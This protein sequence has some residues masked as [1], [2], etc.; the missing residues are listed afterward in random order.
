MTLINIHIK[1]IIIKIYI[2]SLQTAQLLI[3]YQKSYWRRCRPHP[4]EK[5]KQTHSHDKEV[6]ET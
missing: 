1:K 6:S 4:M 2:S 3:T 5:K